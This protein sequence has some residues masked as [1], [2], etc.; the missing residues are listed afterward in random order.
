MPSLTPPSYDLEEMTTVHPVQ[1]VVE[2]K[3]AHTVEM[4]SDMVPETATK[5]FG[6]EPDLRKTLS[7]MLHSSH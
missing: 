7:I 4:V 5:N 3:D 6:W 2:T 1:D